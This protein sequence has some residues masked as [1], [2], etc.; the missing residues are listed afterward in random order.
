VKKGGVLHFLDAESGYSLECCMDLEQKVVISQEV[1]SQELGEE[2]VLLDLTG[3]AYF[4]LDK[5]GTRIW[6]LMGESKSLAQVVDTMLEEYDVSAEI[7]LRDLDALVSK[8]KDS[9]LITLISIE[10]EID[11]FA[12]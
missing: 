3:E 7:L 12:N 5:V 4:G 2:M 10:R 11:E 1:L 6:Q 8:L 9:R